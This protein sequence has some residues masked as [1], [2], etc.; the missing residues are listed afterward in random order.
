MFVN[1]DIFEI[2]VEIKK[3]KNVAKIARLLADYF[4][5]IFNAKTFMNS[6]NTLGFFIWDGKRYRRGDEIAEKFLND[7]HKFNQLEEFKIKVKS[8]RDEFFHHIQYSF[9]ES[10]KIDNSLISFENFIL[11]WN[12]FIKHDILSENFNDFLKDHDP[13]IYSFNYIRHCIDIEP[14]LLAADFETL[15]KS[16]TPN[17]V[18]IFQDWVGDKWQL[19]FEIIGYCLYPKYTFNKAIML[20]GDG[21]NGKSTYLRLLKEILGKENIVSIPLKDLAES[22]FSGAELF[23]KLAN[24]YADLP[25]T[26]ITNTGQFKVLTGE[27]WVSADR[28]FRDRVNFENYAKLIFSCN[29]LPHV[30]DM[31][32]A[33]WRRWLVIKFPNKFSPVD[34][35]FES[36]FDEVEISKIISL[37]LIAFKNVLQ[38]GKFSFEETEADYKELWLKQSDSVYGFLQDSFSTGVLVKELGEK[39]DKQKMY[40]MYVKYCEENELTPVEKN[41]F[42]KRMEI[43]GFPVFK[44]SGKSYYKNIRINEPFRSEFD[45]L[46]VFK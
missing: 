23:G 40:E 44:S 27:D 3:E 29:E 18:K 21:S 5:N 20:V 35:F 34:N 25:K 26:A 7:M 2:D 6:D 17:T 46:E 19:L 9:V 32:P 31:T 42:T 16:L 15:A 12:D 11:S 37:S 45:N 1:Y 43:Y 33:F 28:K 24:I 22:R 39:S 8:L 10:H 30:S 38:R 36:N 13:E 41:T 4:I 14:F